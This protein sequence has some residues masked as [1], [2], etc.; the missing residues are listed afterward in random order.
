MRL[1]SRAACWQEQTR[2]T[3][4]PAALSARIMPMPPQIL[5]GSL[6][7]LSSVAQVGDLRI[8]GPLQTVEEAGGNRVQEQRTENRE[9]RT[10]NNKSRFP[11]GMTAKR[12]TQIS[13]G[14][15][16]QKD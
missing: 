12:Q 16:R 13:F 14:N 3:R 6:I 2:A 10:E 1:D 11:L 9:Q 7:A 15:D 5:Q 4:S 8:W